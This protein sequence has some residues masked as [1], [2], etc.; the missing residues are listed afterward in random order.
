MHFRGKYMR[1]E[2]HLP[3]GTVKDLLNIADYTWQ[4]T[5]R[6]EKPIFVPAGTVIHVIGAFDNSAQN[7]ANPDPSLSVPWGQ[8]R[9]DEMF[10]GQ[11]YYKYVDQSRYQ[12]DGP[13]V[14]M[15]D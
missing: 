11:V 12:Q 7:P 9:W 3:D 10:F 8:Q 15:R 13:F 1:F 5:Y 4:I 14:S 2:A 6:P